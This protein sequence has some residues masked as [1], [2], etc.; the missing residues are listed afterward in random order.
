MRCED[1]QWGSAWRRIHGTTKQKKLLDPIPVELPE[2]YTGWI[3]F[4]ETSD[5]LDNIRQSINKSI[6]YGR[7]DWVEKM[8]INHHLETTLRNA[9]RPKKN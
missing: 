7:E 4:S 8:V 3:N 1:W 6:P 5:E 2:D 9:G